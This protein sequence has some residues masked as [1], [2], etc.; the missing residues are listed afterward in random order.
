VVDH[1]GAPLTNELDPAAEAEVERLLDRDVQ[2]TQLLELPRPAA[3]R[4]RPD[5][6]LRRRRAVLVTFM[7]SPPQ[8]SERPMTRSSLIV[9][10]TRHWHDPDLSVAGQTRLLIAT[11]GAAA[12]VDELPPLIRALIQ[13]ASEILVIT[14]ILA[15]R[16][17]WL[18]SD[19]DRAR[20]EADERLGLVLGQIEALAPETE[21]RVQIGDETPLTAFDDAIRSFRPDH[22]L[23]ALRSA[24]HDAWQERGLID[25]LRSAFH[26]PMTVFEIDQAGHV[27]PAE[28]QA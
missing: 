7:R 26:I 20:Y 27:P 4:R 18:A 1:G 24:D 25:A 10:G 5:A 14:P 21:T 6:G 12:N 22:I 8:V 17:R 2:E 16:L 9:V 3:G 13:S 11:G 19:T 15:S 23:I 28:P